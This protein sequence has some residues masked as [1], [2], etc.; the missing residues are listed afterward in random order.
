MR[1]RLVFLSLL[2]SVSATFTGCQNA[3][4]P[5]DN[6]PAI[7]RD[8]KLLYGNDLPDNDIAQIR[9][10]INTLDDIDKR[11]LSIATYVHNEAEVMTGEMRRGGVYYT[12]SLRRSKD[13]W[14][15]SEIARWEII[16]MCGG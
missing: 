1:L 9:A 14:N 8:G 10:L 15:V 16:S 3:D 12:I 11:I 13:G 7:I 4:A 6:R 2:L 5:A